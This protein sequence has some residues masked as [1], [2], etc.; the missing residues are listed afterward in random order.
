[1]SL[2]SYIAILGRQPEFGLVELESVL[3]SDAVEPFGRQAARL[4]KLAEID[5]LGGTIKLAEVLY[6]GPTHDAKDLPVEVD[7][8]PL[9]TGKTPFA[10]SLY[11]IQATRRYVEVVGLALKK[12][13]KARGSV[14]L[15]QPTDGTAVSAAG[16]KHN[17]VLEKGFELL[18]VV[19]GQQMVVA[20]T[21]GVQD[22]DAYAER[23]HGRP[24][25]SGRVGMLPPK[26]AQIM[27]NTTTAPVVADPFCGTGVVLQEA[28]LLGRMAWGADKS[29]DMVMATEQNMTWLDGRHSRSL[30]EATVRQADARKVL[31]PAGCAVVSEGYLGPNQITPPS[32]RQLADMQQEL[33]SLY[34][35]TL[36]SLARQLS[37]GADL[38]ICVPA[39]RVERQWHYLGLVDELPDLG[40]TLKGF[41][42]TSTPLLYAR[43]DQIVGRQLLLLRKK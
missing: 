9:A 29:S 3:G 8:L 5:R 38:T 15:V 19:A 13:L 33:L 39:W 41:R 22:V 11:G 4:A 2:Q 40:Y 31:V 27:V 43:D 18:V 42:T 12:R 35:D 1:M 10:V 20:R 17:Q 7:G 34:R 26:L 6:D 30:P 32:P 14:R 21:V 16:L 36:R 28:R 25:R 23:D 24:V 37:P